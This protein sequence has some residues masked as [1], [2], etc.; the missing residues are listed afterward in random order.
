MKRT[1]KRRGLRSHA[2]GIEPNPSIRTDSAMGVS[3][4]RVVRR[5]L[6]ETA[7]RVYRG[8]DIGPALDK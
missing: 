1:D 2:A 6:R 4:R 5:A 8:A 3:I 7:T